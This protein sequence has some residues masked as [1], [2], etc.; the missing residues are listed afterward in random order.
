MLPLNPM[1][2]ILHHSLCMPRLLGFPCTC[3]DRNLHTCHL[4]PSHSRHCTYM[5]T[6]LPGGCLSW[7]DRANSFHYLF[8][9]CTCQ[10][11]TQCRHQRVQSGLARTQ[12]CS[13]PV[14]RCLLMMSFLRDTPRRRPRLMLLVGLSICP[15]DTAG[16]QLPVPQSHRIYL[17]RTKRTWHLTFDRS[18]WNTCRL[19]NRCTPHCPPST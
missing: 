12:V 8:L 9:P 19:H 6:A 11:D 3:L 10:R 1:N 4:H 15:Q 7:S 14:H 5:P 2:T 16:N 17:P 13:H 18:P